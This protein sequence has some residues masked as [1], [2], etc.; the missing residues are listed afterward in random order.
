MQRIAFQLRL[1]SGSKPLYDEAHPHVWPQLLAELTAAG[2]PEYTIFRRGQQLFLSML[3]PTF[4]RLLATMARSEV[5]QRWQQAMAPLLEPVPS[6]Q[7]W[8]AFA[9]MDKV[10]Y[11]AGPPSRSNAFPTAAPETT[12]DAA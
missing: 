12:N 7:P 8:E 3:V 6:L 1:R 10:F 4:D 2:D 5:N 11:L 9:M